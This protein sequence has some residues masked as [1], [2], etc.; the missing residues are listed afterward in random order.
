MCSRVEDVVI[1]VGVAEDGVYRKDGRRK[2]EGECSV[3]K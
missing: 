2:K 1:W 3:F